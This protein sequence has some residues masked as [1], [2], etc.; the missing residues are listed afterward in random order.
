MVHRHGRD[1]SLQRGLGA[2]FAIGADLIQQG[3]VVGGQL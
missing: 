1:R 2:S 3:D